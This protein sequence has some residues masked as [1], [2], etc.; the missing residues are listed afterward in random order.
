V[1]FFW[2]GAATSPEAPGKSSSTFV[3]AAFALD[4]GPRFFAMNQKSPTRDSLEGRTGSMSTLLHTV[5]AR[6]NLPGQQD[7]GGVAV[8]VAGPLSCSVL[9]AFNLFFGQILPRAKLGIGGPARNC[10]VYGG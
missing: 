8:P 3:D 4:V 10:P 5:E 9:E 6:L 2:L 1:C 7:H